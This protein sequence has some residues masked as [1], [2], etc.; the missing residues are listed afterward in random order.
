M[1]CKVDVRQEVAV[2][3]AELL[4]GE[5]GPGP[6]TVKFGESA[7]GLQAVQQ[8]WIAQIQKKKGVR[9]SASS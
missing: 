4:A 8:F 9:G 2:E 7:L 5:A 6:L 1:A 3:V